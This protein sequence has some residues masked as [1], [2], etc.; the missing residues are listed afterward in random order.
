MEDN[1]LPIF[2]PTPFGEKMNRWT[3]EEDAIIAEKYDSMSYAELAKLI[4]RTEAAVR[5][6]CYEKKFRKQVAPWTT[7]EVHQLFSWYESHGDGRGEVELDALAESLGRVKSNVCRK[8]R[9]LGIT[10]SQRQVGNTMKEEMKVRFAHQWVDKPH[11]RGMAGKHH[12]EESRQAMTIGQKNRYAKLVKSARSAQALK[13]VATRIDRYGSGR[14]GKFE[15]AYS[16]C[17]RGKRED[18][19]DYFFRSSWEANYA[20]YLNML[21]KN[22]KIAKW[23]YE[24]ETFIFPDVIKGQRTYLPDFKIWNN[25][26]N[27]CYHEVKGW[28][29]SASRSKLKKMH[30]YYPEVEVIVIGPKEYKSISEYAAMIPG[31]EYPS[32]SE[33]KEKG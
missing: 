33:P 9:E 11:P 19:G 18:I 10:N 3:L 16:R 2:G 15:N 14:I 21:I 27:I 30:K 5:N 23:D 1:A 13:S 32:K 17:K 20:R 28:M 4:G 31:W 25:D 22:H 29:D 6:R 26:G 24:S 12:T 8:A 7:D